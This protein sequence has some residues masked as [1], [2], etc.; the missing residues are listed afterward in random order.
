MIFGLVMAF[1]SYIHL[2]CRVE[3]V[4]N[5]VGGSQTFTG[6]IHGGYCNVLSEHSRQ[7]LWF[8][9]LLRESPGE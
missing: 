4:D 5:V 2:Y 8:G 3:F 7:S 9:F 1:L 6:W